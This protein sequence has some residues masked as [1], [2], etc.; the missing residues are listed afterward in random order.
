M[1]ASEQAIR[2]F[3]GREIERGIPASRIV[4]AGFSQGGAMAL[5]TGLRYPDKLAG[6]MALSAYLP[7]AAKVA[8][9]RNPENQHTSIFMG[10]GSIDNVVPVPLARKSQAY[11]AQLGYNVEWHEY[12]MMHE[13]CREELDD[14]GN[15]MTNVLQ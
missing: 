4:L 13:V 2:Q 15:W 1:R 5:Q 11:L 3:L 7:L 14:I 8:Q 9:E 6:I 12:P 10:H